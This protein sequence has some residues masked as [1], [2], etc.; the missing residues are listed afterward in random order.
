MKG[1]EASQ[2]VVN[3]EVHTKLRRIVSQGFSESF[4]Q[5][6]SEE[7]SKVIELFMKRLGMV[8]D[9][10]AD[11][12]PSPHNDGWTCS[13]NM[14]RYS[15]FF[16]FDVMCRLVFGR[17]YGMLETKENHW[18]PHAIEGQLRRISFLQSMPELE[19]LGLHRLLFPEARRR[20]FEFSAKSKEMLDER[21]TR[22]RNHKSGP[23]DIFSVLLAARDQVTG[24]KLSEHQLWAESNLL[25][26]AGKTDVYSSLATS[27]M[28]S[29]E[30][31]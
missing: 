29:S 27:S 11:T 5:S 30:I 15:D 21:T 1:V 3:R 7:M 18:I 14:A 17:S 8:E 22:Q 4:L 12:Q 25:I 10:F 13:K 28:N 19:D 23:D 6:Y 26:V 9:D 2:S 24:E 31:H 16:T 20:A